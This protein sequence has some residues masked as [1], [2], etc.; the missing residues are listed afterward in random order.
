MLKVLDHLYKSQLFGWS[1]GF[2]GTTMIS[3]TKEYV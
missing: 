2:H 1:R 3:M